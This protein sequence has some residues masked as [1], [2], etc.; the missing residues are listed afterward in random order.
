MTTMIEV[1]VPQ[2]PESV[3]D[4]TLERLLSAGFRAQRPEAA[5]VVRGDLLRAELG[6]QA[7]RVTTRR[8]AMNRASRRISALT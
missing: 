8:L 3:A 5:A 2:L 7:H 6:P 1:R 4:A